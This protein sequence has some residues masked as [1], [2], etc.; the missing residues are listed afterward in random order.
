[1]SVKVKEINPF[2]V[3]NPIRVVEVTTK[4]L[5]AKNVKDGIVYEGGTF[6]DTY[7]IDSA[8]KVNIYKHPV[9]MTDD[10]LFTKL[11][12]KGRDLYLYIIHRLPKNQDYMELKLKKVCASTKMSRNSVVTALK[13]L[14]IAS[15]ITPKSQSI[16]WINPEFMF[17]GNRVNF[18]RGEG[19]QCLETVGRVSR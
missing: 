8:D 2:V 17:N 10:F 9:G 13:E 11:N 15:V 1:M 4:K 19:E 14:K 6:N 16:Y 18:Y 3:N 5:L 12:S 7:Y